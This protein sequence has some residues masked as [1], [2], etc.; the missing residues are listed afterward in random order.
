[1]AVTCRSSASSGNAV[2]G[3]GLQALQFRPRA[4][5]IVTQPHSAR[6]SLPPQSLQSGTLLA[7]MTELV[8]QAPTLVVAADQ[9]SVEALHATGRHVAQRRSQSEAQQGD[10]NEDS[11]EHDI[12]PVILN[13]T[14]HC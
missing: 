4:L 7:Q 8:P 3:R 13:G 2:T 5:D 1:M 9:L 14:N 12:P 6:R 11:D 10:Q